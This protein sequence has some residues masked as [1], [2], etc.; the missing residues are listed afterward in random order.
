MSFDFGGM[1]NYPV[2]IFK[3]DCVKSF[4]R[5]SVDTDKQLIYESKLVTK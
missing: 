3:D 5:K 1:L 4:A 2:D